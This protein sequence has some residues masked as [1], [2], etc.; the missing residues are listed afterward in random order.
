MSDPAG[1]VVL[2][3]SPDTPTE[4]VDSAFAWA[5]VRGCLLLAVR[6]WHEPDLPLGGW[7]EPERTA[8]WDAADRR[9]RREL[10]HALE[11]AQLAHPTVPVARIVVD[12]D[13]VSFLTA[14]STRAEVLVLGRPRQPGNRCS[15][16]VDA[17][18]HRTACPVLVVPPTPCPSSAPR[19]PAASTS[20][21]STNGSSTNG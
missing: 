1:R 12:D 16:V 15:P 3:V 7:L 21:W 11:P 6:T 19:T 14:L 20:G 4:A 8:R 10:D 9:A 5:A 17:L 18:V 13:P 2:A